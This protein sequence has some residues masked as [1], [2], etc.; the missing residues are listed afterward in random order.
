[1]FVL[2]W[3]VM[4]VIDESS[5]LWGVDWNDPEAHLVSFV[6]TLVGHDGTYGQTIYA[7]KVYAAA[8]LR[9]G[10][11]FVD[12]LERLGDG[13]MMIDYGRFHQSVEDRELRQRLLSIAPKRQ[14]PPTA[15]QA[16]PLS[17]LP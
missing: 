8:A 12:V 2:T 16:T 17:G 13:R 1:M 9:V 14:Q 4:H 15:E 10:H 3:T 7:R 6:T 5:P 11:R